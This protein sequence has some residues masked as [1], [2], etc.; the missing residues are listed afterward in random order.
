M[1]D[2][3][4]FLKDFSNK[5]WSFAEVPITNKNENER[6]LPYILQGSANVTI[7][8]LKEYHKWLTNNYDITPKN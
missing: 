2:I 1:P 6:A 3:E 5:D 4:N 8:I 7:E